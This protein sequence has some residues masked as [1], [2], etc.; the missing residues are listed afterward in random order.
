MGTNYYLYDRPPCSACGR[1]YDR[2][3]IGKSSA[4][5]VFSLHVIPEQG[6]NG[7]D[8]W[9]HRWARD[10][11][12]IE[13]EYGHRVSPS[14]MEAV[15]LLRQWKPWEEARKKVPSGYSS[16]ADFHMQN[17]SQEGDFGLL[18]GAARSRYREYGGPTY[19]LVEGEFS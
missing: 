13:D 7:L 19:D 18:R 3:H 9:K 8:D 1:E 17:H 11:A 14:E 2:I 16:W 15:I 4:G 12:Y 10:G 6:I 5:W